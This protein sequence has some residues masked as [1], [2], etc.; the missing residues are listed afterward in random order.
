MSLSETFCWKSSAAEVVLRGPSTKNLEPVTDAGLTLAG[1]A[2]ALACSWPLARSRRRS[3]GF[4]VETHP[5]RLRILASVLSVRPRCPLR[6]TWKLPIEKRGRCAILKS[7]ATEVL[8]FVRTSK[9]VAADS[10]ADHRE[11]ALIQQSA[12][13]RSRLILAKSP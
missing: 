3:K 4:M 1:R 12:A 7:R 8:P 10:K 11:A 2:V 9:T 5:L 13:L 6:A